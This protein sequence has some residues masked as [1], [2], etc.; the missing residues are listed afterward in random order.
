MVL[1][2]EF[3]PSTP[4]WGTEVVPT[5]AQSMQVMMGESQICDFHPCWAVTHPSN[6]SS[7]SLSGDLKSR[8]ASPKWRWGGRRC[9]VG[10]GCWRRPSPCPWLWVRGCVCFRVSPGKPQRGRSFQ[11]PPSLGVSDPLGSP[12]WCWVGCRTPRLHSGG[13]YTWL[14]EEIKK[15][16]ERKKAEEKLNRELHNCVSGRANISQVCYRLCRCPRCRPGEA[17]AGPGQGWRRRGAPNGLQGFTS[18]TANL[19]ALGAVRQSWGAPP[20]H[21]LGW[22]A[23]QPPHL[24]G[25]RPF[26]AAEPGSD[27]TPQGCGGCCFSE[28]FTRARD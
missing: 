25:H 26:P 21:A 10:A 28:V 16:G 20:A 18:L 2:V 13:G 24:G 17:D 1:Q 8:L 3:Q 6:P 22:V 14:R 11:K 23:S 27:R 12:L 7:Q 9:V 19:L 5:A 4:C 15:Q